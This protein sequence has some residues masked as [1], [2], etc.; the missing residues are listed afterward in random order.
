MHPVPA[1]RI[2]LVIY[3]NINFILSL[4]SCCSYIGSHPLL[5]ELLVGDGGEA[6]G[7]VQV[8]GHGHYLLS[9][10]GGS[11]VKLGPAVVRGHH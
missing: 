2:I 9:R 6:G 4:Q 8:R 7:L 5:R 11:L 10:E 1:N 3:E